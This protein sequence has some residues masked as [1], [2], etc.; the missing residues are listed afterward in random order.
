MNKKLLAL[1]ALVAGLSGGLMMAMLDA[2]KEYKLVRTEFPAREG[3]YVIKMICEEDP[4]TLKTAWWGAKEKA[5]FDGH[6]HMGTHR[7]YYAGQY[8][9]HK[10]KGGRNNWTVNRNVAPTQCRMY[11]VVDTQ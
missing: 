10:M 1:V 6:H 7:V 11:F 5:L 4:A 2:G 9:I 8:F 3:E